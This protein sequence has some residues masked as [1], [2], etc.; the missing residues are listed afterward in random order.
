[1]LEVSDEAIETLSLDHHG[2]VAGICK[3][4]RIAERI[5][6]Q[7]KVHD[8]RIVSPGQAVV[9]MIINGLGFTNRRLYL[10]HQF[11]ANKPIELLLESGLKAEDITDYTLGHTLDEIYE[12]GSSELF[13]TIGFSIALEHKLLGSNLHLDTT[14]IS[15][16]GEYKSSGDEHVVN[17][18]HGYSKDMRRDLKQVVMSLAVSGASNLPIFMEALDG[19][20]SDKTSFHETI[21]KINDFKA[22]INLDHDFKWVADSALYTPDKL[23]QSEYLWLTRVPENIKEAN[24]LVHKEDKTIIWQKYDE[25]YK[26]AEFDSTYG[27]ISQRWLLIFSSQAYKREKNTL[28]KQLTKK[29]IELEKALWHLGNEVFNCEDDAKLALKVIIKKFKLYNIDGMIETIFKYNKRGKPKD[30]DIKVASGYKVVAT[31]KRNT[32]LIEQLQNSK[33]RFILATNDL[34]KDS[35][36]NTAMLKEYK[37]QQCVESGFRFI[38]D[39]WF[40]VDSVFLKSPKR[41]EALMMVMTLCLLVY[42]FAQY[43]IRKSLNEHNDTVPNQLGKKVQNP[44]LRWIFQLMEGVGIVRTWL[45]RINLQHKDLVT[46]LTKLRQQILYH[47][48]STVCSMYGLIYKNLKLGLGM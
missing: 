45:D 28:D 47:L 26:F 8:K 23:L 20:S 6:E 10:S 33:G 9:S 24:E 25:E 40:M 29:D 19:N 31:F 15:V 42:N 3:E 22:Q 14:S 36:P 39:P 1:M 44:T 11:F 2:I 34:D 38:K 48:G 32:E 4:L 21:K 17:I 18:T 46:N 43:R 35:Y 27:G 16:D 13:A 30:T 41:L 5:N 37:Q 12:Y 7:L